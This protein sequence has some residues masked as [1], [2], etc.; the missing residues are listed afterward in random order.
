MLFLLTA[1]TALIRAE[2]NATKNATK[3]ATE[4]ATKNA[5]ENAT[6]ACTSGT[7]GVDTAAKCQLKTGDIIVDAG[8]VGKVC[9]ICHQCTKNCGKF[10]AVGPGSDMKGSIAWGDAKGA[11]TLKLEGKGK[12]NVTAGG[13]D[14]TYVT[15]KTADDKKTLC[16]KTT[17]T[18]DGKKH[19]F[20]WATG[21]VEK[22]VLKGNKAPKKKHDYAGSYELDLT[23]AGFDDEFPILIVA[24]A[25]AGGGAVIILLIVLCCCCSPK[26]KEK[27]PSPFADGN[28]KKP[29]R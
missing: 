25:A 11:G 10:L 4:N 14:L 27:P 5:T 21:D 9:T 8:C 24:A 23:E 16:F 7:L 15:Y 28:N 1:L 20:Q 17:V 29:K 12:A 26:K 3:N 13:Y 22:D 6:K 2:E 19:K 18:G